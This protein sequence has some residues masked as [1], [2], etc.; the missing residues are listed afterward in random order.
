MFKSITKAYQTLSDPQ[1]RSLYDRFGEQAAEEL[2]NSGLFQRGA[3]GGGARQPSSGPRKAS[4]GPRLD[5]CVTGAYRTPRVSLQGPVSAFAMRVP[6]ADLYLGSTVR[7][8]L[9]RSSPCADCSGSGAMAG[10]RGAKA[11]AGEA[12]RRGVAAPT[13]RASPASWLP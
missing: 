6:L 11:P 9:A 2:N 10:K 5:P 7:H 1:K 12:G 8:T 13:A 3:G 4:D